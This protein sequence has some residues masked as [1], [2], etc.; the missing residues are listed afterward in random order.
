MSRAERRRAE[1]A[2]RKRNKRKGGAQDAPPIQD[3]SLVGNAIRRGAERELQ[4]VKEE[5]TLEALTLMFAI[6]VKVLKDDYWKKSYK[7]KLPEFVDKMF[8]VYHK[9]E[10]GEFDINKMKDQL[11]E[12]AGIKFEG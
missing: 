3:V 1:R 7:Q 10:S 5:A 2:E 12:D 4:R 9:I 8:D 11:W 6:P